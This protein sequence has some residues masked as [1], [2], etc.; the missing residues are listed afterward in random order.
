M[1]FCDVCGT[2]LRST[3]TGLYCS[4]CEKAVDQKGR[5][6][7]VITELHFQSEVVTLEATGE[8][9]PTIDETCPQCGHGTAYFTSQQMRSADE[10]QT[11]FFEC[12]KCGHKYRV[13]A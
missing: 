10:G 11:V 9:R 6:T 12:C 5:D 3:A 7:R 13:N 4:C 8:S 1:D 2:L